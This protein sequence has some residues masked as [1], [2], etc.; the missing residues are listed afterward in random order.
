MELHNC[1][2]M[3]TLGNIKIYL[4]D[5]IKFLISEQLKYFDGYRESIISE[6]QL[7]QSNFFDKIK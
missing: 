4:D 5:R 1:I 2:A 7:F 3:T 6:L